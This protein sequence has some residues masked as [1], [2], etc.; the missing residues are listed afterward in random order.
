MKRCYTE[1]YDA[2]FA[3][4][5]PNPYKQYTAQAQQWSEGYAQAIKDERSATCSMLLPNDA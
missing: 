1:G 4:P 2:W 5:R 3:G